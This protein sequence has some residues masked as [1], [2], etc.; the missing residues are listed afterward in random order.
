MEKAEN[1]EASAPLNPSGGL[2]PP[3]YPESTLGAKN[4]GM[5]PQ[6]EVGG[7]PPV[8]PHQGKNS[9]WYIM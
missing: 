2:P 6:L 4:L 1:L 8:F 7:P 3:A 5:Y 9:I